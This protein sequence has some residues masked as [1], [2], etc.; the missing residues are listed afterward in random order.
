MVSPVQGG[1]GEIT[2]IFFSMTVGLATGMGY[3]TFAF[4]VAVIK[5]LL[6]FVLSKTSFGEVIEMH[7]GE[8]GV[9]SKLNG[10]SVFWF[11]LKINGT[12]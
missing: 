7:K 11:A 12:K 3:I 4:S 10:G 6:F 5:C 8:Y 1:S 2:G 9:S